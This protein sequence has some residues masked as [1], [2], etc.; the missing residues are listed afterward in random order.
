MLFF[1]F[2]GALLFSRNVHLAVQTGHSSSVHIVSCLEPSGF[3]FSGSD[4][5]SVRL[6]DIKSK[7]LIRK[8]FVSHLP[9]Y[10]ITVSEQTKRFAAVSGSG[11]NTILSV[12]DWTD[13]SELYA[14]P[15][16]DTPLF[17][18]FS[19]KGNFIVAGFAKWNSLQFFN[20]ENGKQL[21]YLSRGFGIV[22]FVF[23]S[24]SERT[25]GSYNPSTGSIIYWD[26]D[27]GNEKTRRQTIQNLEFVQEIDDDKRYIAAKNGKELVIIDTTTGEA[28]ARSTVGLIEDIAV[29][30]HSGNIA[31]L[32]TEGERSRI[33]NFRFY[34]NSTYL[35]KQYVPAGSIE[36]QPND[37]AFYDDFLYLGQPSGEIS[38]ISVRSG[39]SM[40]FA[41]NELQPITGIS[42]RGKYLLLSSA[43]HILVLS[44]DF[45]S[46]T[47]NDIPEITYLDGRR[48]INPLHGATSI[49]YL[50]YSNYLLWNKDEKN[51]TI[52]TINPETGF[53]DDLYT[54]FENPLISVDV[55]RNTVISLEKSGRLTVRNI[56]NSDLEFEYQ[57]LGMKVVGGSTYNGVI[58]GKNIS[59]FFETPILKID[60]STGETVGLESKNFI[61]FALAYNSSR[62]WVYSLGLSRS[63]DGTVLT[64]LTKHW[65]SDLER[66]TPISAVSNEDLNADIAVDKKD[67]SIYSTI[68]YQGIKAWDRNDKPGII[69]EDNNALPRTVA[70][71]NNAVYA[72]NR[73][74]SVSIW[75]KK[76]GDHLLDF[77]LFKDKSWLAVSAGGYFLESDHGY[78]RRFLKLIEDDKISS[79][80]L[81][82]YEFSL[83]E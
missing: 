15:L 46:D 58:A 11:K 73:D 19:P 81:D 12:W 83:P 8:I 40:G 80:S 49:E 51:G 67:S 38:V 2:S 77:Y 76:T 68:G 61:V 30:K 56:Y 16:E 32:Y 60:T 45:F 29:D 18:K 9:V 20:G 37:F 71:E 53:I 24:D 27:S 21:P 23:I 44:S 25:L 17:I 78:A 13:G 82:R 57:A 66:S 50:N 74:G 26:V 69:F 33:A 31:C 75:S 22:S 72:I 52:Y 41:K 14:V 3:L 65:G 7:T 6:W 36:E 62:E 63:S 39:S 5:G 28:A 34:K 48:S 64:R 70:V 10:H 55:F 47:K 35:S 42:G 79:R 43:D 1:L 54:D 59:N 4:D